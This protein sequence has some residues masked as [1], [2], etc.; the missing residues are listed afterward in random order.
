MGESEWGIS[1]CAYICSENFNL[2]VAFEVPTQLA[3]D[4]LLSVGGFL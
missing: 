4:A 2:C 3:G 1:L